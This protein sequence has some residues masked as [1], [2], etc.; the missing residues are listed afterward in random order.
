[1]RNGGEGGRGH[2]QEK[3]LTGG[4]KNNIVLRE[5]EGGKVGNRLLLPDDLKADQSFTQLERDQSRGKEKKGKSSY[6]TFKKGGGKIE[7]QRLFSLPRLS[8]FPG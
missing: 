2:E 5:K 7:V 3:C 1:M 6:L 4:H 8:T